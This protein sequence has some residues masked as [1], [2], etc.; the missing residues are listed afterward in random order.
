MIELL[1]LTFNIAYIVVIITLP[2]ALVLMI[3]TH[4]ILSLKLTWASF[5]KRW[6]IPK[7]IESY[8]LT[9]RPNARRDKYITSVDRRGLLI[10]G[11]V[12]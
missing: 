3:I 9:T 12:K 10:E 1:A 7:V 2:L 4:R 11:H 5:E 8:K 6:L